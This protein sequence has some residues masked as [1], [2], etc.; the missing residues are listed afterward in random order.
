MNGLSIIIPVYNEEVS[1]RSTVDKIKDLFTN[2]STQWE[3]ICVNDGSHDKSKE[4]LEQIDN[5]RLV[6]HKLNKGYGASI[7]SGLR[8]AKFDDICITDA[9]GTY[10]I[11]MITKLYKYYESNQLDMVVGARTGEDVSYPFLK[12][13]PKFFIKSLANYIAEYKIPDIN[14]G[15]RI[16]RKETAMEFFHLYPNGFSF[17]TTI[18][19]GMLCSDYN[20]EFYPINYFKR[21]GKSK[22]KPIKD[23]ISFFN[24]L[25]KI[26]LYFRP[27]KFFKPI[28]FIFTILAIAFMIRDIFILKDLTQGGILF[29]TIAILFFSLGLIA[30]LVI[31][32]SNHLK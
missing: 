15:L 22:I 12:K 32:R 17:T 21:E 19:M 29:P 13:I 9:D 16:F 27:F 20:V 6:N 8:I 4:T 10:P 14:S 24:L 2:T 18:T 3:I 11:D 23:T 28:I 7:K 5:I 25:L 1:I 26:A 30:D 31:K